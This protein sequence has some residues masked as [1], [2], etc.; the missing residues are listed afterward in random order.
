MKMHQDQISNLGATALRFIARTG[1]VC[2]DFL[3][4]P[5]CPV[6][7]ARL[8]NSGQLCP[9]CWQTLDMIAPPYCDRLGIPFAL[10]G[11]GKPVSARALANPPEYDRARAAVLYNDPARR[12]VLGLKYRDRHDYIAIM[13]RM[14]VS[15]G[16]ELLKDADLILP[17]P[18]HWTRLWSRRFNQSVQLASAISRITHI[19][20]LLTGLDRIRRTPRQ[21]G[22]TG[23]QRRRNVSGAFVVRDQAVPMISRRRVILV[24]DVLTTGATVEACAQVL[25]KSGAARVDILT[26]ALVEDPIEGAY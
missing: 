8:E 25:R 3:L 21:V 15:A 1:A 24:D 10:P 13:V 18:L 6:C 17:V 4:P 20:V 14:M 12:L 5:Q 9:G 22:L 23:Q 19:P 16:G 26:F 11:S 7:R 2:A